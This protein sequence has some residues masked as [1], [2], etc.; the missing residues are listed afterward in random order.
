LSSKSFD[1]IHDHTIDLVPTTTKLIM[2]DGRIVKL[3]GIA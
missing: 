3:I 1:E 2:G